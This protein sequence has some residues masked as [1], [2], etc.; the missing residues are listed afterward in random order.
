MRRAYVLIL[1]MATAFLSWA[2]CRSAA[3]GPAAGPHASPAAARLRRPVALLLAGG[4]LLVANRA[5]GVIS[6]I[7]PRTSAVV[8]EI[9][10]GGTLADLTPCPDRSSVLA[11]DQAAGQLV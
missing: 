2:A 9:S 6:V 5:D 4:H 7:D 3:E 8:S 1:V 10:V 11:V